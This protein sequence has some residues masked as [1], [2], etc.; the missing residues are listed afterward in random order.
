[1]FLLIIDFPHSSSQRGISNDLYWCL[2]GARLYLQNTYSAVGDI[3]KQKGTYDSSSECSDCA[4]YSVRDHKEDTGKSAAWVTDR[5]PRHDN[6]R[7]GS[8]WMCRER[9]TEK[10]RNLIYRENEGKAKAQKEAK[11]EPRGT[12]QGGCQKSLSSGVPGT[13]EAGLHS[14][15]GTQKVACD[16]ITT[17]FPLVLITCNQR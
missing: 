14:D 8:W 16:F 4:E 15:P 11:Q 13:N 1:M 12:R 3:D 10:M 17:P 5:Q 2:F 9:H 7:S 6:A